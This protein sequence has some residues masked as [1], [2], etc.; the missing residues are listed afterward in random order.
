MGR[1]GIRGGI[2]RVANRRSRPCCNCQRT[3]QQGWEDPDRP[4]RNQGVRTLTHTVNV[5]AP[6]HKVPLRPAKLVRGYMW[7][8][9]GAGAEGWAA[10]PDGA[11][12]AM[13]G[14]AGIPP[15]APA[16]P[17]GGP[18]GLPLHPIM[19]IPDFILSLPIIM[20]WFDMPPADGPAC[21]AVAGGDLSG[22]ACATAKAGARARKPGSKSAAKRLDFNKRVIAEKSFHFDRGA[23]RRMKSVATEQ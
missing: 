19:S 4:V 2:R 22:C 1:M 23:G 16:V 17:C 14:E 11:G 18:H 6:R 9:I 15:M 10:E 21:V 8:F 7:S 3:G 20:C 5:R 13:L 12:L